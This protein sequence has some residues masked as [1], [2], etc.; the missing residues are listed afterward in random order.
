M[1]QNPPF[2]GK[3]SFFLGRGH[4]PYPDPSPSTVPPLWNSG[5]ATDDDGERVNQTNLMHSV[6]RRR[7]AARK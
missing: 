2:S 4:S 1:H 7:R 3:N 5:S 6:Y